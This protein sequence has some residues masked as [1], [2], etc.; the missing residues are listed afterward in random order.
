MSFGLHLHAYQQPVLQ[1]T[2]DKNIFFFVPKLSLFQKSYYNEW[3]VS[4]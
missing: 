3:A 2:S 4:V 1:K